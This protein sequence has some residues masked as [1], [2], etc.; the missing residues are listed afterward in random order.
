MPTTLLTIGNVQ[1]L[2]QNIVYALPARLVF[3]KSDQSLETSN[4]VGGTFAALT[5]ANTTGVNVAAGFVRNTNSTTAN[6]ILKAT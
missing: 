3:I 6:V 4:E 5:G 1:Q 2:V